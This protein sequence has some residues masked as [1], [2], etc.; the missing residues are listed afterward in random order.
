MQVFHCRWEAGANQETYVRN[1][2]AR[3]NLVR[4]IWA[5]RG[6]QG[7]KVFEFIISGINDPQRARLALISELEK[8]IAVQDPQAAP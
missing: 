8:M 4:G 3:M 2:S 1:E 5:G 6:N 7:Q